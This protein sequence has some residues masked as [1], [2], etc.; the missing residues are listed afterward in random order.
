MA[1]KAKISLEKGKRIADIVYDLEESFL[2]VFRKYSDEEF[3]P[4]ECLNSLAIASAHVIQVI[5]D[6]QPTYGKDVLG[7]FIKVMKESHKLYK[8]NPTADI[9]PIHTTA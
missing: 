3:D 7:P 6:A 4:E 1:K 8:Q 9:N 2:A 5:E